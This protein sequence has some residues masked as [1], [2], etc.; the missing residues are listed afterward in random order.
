MADAKENATPANHSATP[1]A[2]WLTLIGLQEDGLA[3]LCPAARHALA[4]AQHVF[5]APRHLALAGVAAAPHGPGRAWPQ[6]FDLAP[7]LALRG[8]AVVVLASGDP[9]WYGVGGSLAA[10]LSPQEWRCYAQSPTFSLLAARLGWRLEETQCLGL[11]ADAFERL[12]PHLAPGQQLAV[13]LRDGAAAADLAQW[14]S[15]RGWGESDFSVLERLGGPHE[16]IRHWRTPQ[17]HSLQG[18]AQQGNAQHAI[19]ALA[20]DPAQ[21][22]AAVAVRARGGPALPTVPGRP[23]HWF[24]HDGQITKSPM[25]AITLA[26]LAPQRGQRLWDLGAGSGSISVEWCLAGG[27]AVAVER[28]AERV[29]HITRNAQRFG[30]RH[31]LRVVHS[32]ALEALPALHQQGAPDAVFVGGGFDGALFDWLRQHLSKGCRMVVNAVTLD[33][34]ALL[35]QLHAEH[36]GQL[37]KLDW[38]QAQ[39]LGRMHAWQPARTLVQWSWQAPGPARP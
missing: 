8:Q 13:L 17:G 16:R 30:L 23:E 37:I 19:A 12:L 32:P 6:P 9:F 31:A 21:A 11:H 36:G 38:A 34:Q 22:P 14:L 10:H 39:P 7:L 4:Q 25:R 1:D 5:G 18:H 24:A 28:A 26:A 15:E 2:P 3:S 33:T 27:R 35:L 20:A 29:A